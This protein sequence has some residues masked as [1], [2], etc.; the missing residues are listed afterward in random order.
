MFL[1]PDLDVFDPRVG[2][3]PAQSACLTT[4]RR[5]HPK[6]QPE[7]ART[8]PSHPRQSAAACA[9]LIRKYFRLPLRLHGDATPQH[10]WPTTRQQ[11]GGLYMKPRKTLVLG[12]QATTNTLALGVSLSGR[13]WRRASKPFTTQSITC[14][15]DNSPHTFLPSLRPP[16]R[17]CQS[18]AIAWRMLS[19]AVSLAGLRAA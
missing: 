13:E 15:T 8:S 18:V 4:S 14:G 9:S 11:L 12:A 2:V 19:W 10:K 17:S 1:T 3:G 5:S 7:S 6:P 16:S